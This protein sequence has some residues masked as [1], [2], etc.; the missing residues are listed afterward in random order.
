[1]NGWH[2]HLVNE[3]AMVPVLPPTH[4]VSMTSYAHTLQPIQG[5]NSPVSDPA[6]ESNKPFASEDC[7]RLTERCPHF[8]RETERCPH[9]FSGE[10]KDR[11]IHAN[12]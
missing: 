1:M 10:V 4:A 9:F 8:F 3:S 5:L 11:P 7:N 12:R 6:S 2:L